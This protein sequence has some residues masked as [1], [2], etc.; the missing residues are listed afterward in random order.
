MLIATLPVSLSPYKDLYVSDQKGLLLVSQSLA[1]SPLTPDIIH[2]LF[3]KMTR[4]IAAVE[5]PESVFQVGVVTSFLGDHWRQ[6]VGSES[7]MVQ[8]LLVELLADM[9]AADV[10]QELSESKAFQV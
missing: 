9:E 7:P 6:L 4:K 8:Q 3:L 10:K 2:A 5:S 1:R